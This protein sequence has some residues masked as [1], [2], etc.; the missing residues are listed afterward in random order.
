MA[1]GS[2][3]KKYLEGKKDYVAL[4]KVS[5][6]DYE[7]TN[8]ELIRYF[9]EEENI[10]GIYV[11]LNKAFDIV[12]ERLTENSVD[13]RVIIFI[14][15]VVKRSKNDVSKTEDCLFIGSPEKLSDISIAMDQAVKA[16]PG[17]D[18][19]VFFDSL[20][21]LLLYNNPT[22]VARFIHFLS[23]K[24]RSWWVKGIIISLRREKD[25]ELIEELLQ[26]CD[27]QIDA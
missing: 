15:A 16:L 21:T 19:F 9:T 10:P 26:F 24:I 17:K 12:K 27:I 23:N 11:T 5:S 25:K 18:K 2:K 13:T 7:K 8:V 14:D 4:V 20:S 3:Y 22:S 1:S 6:K